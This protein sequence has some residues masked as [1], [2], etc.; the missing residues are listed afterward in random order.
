[1]LL[2]ACSDG[3][4]GRILANFTKCNPAEACPG[5]PIPAVSGRQPA[6]WSIPVPRRPQ[7]SSRRGRRRRRSRS[8]RMGRGRRA[9]RPPGISRALSALKGRDRPVTLSRSVSSGARQPYERVGYR[10]V[11]EPDAAQSASR[12]RRASLRSG[13]APVAD[14]TGPPGR[15]RL[16]DG[17]AAIAS[18]GLRRAP[19]W[20]RERGGRDRHPSAGAPSRK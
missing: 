20:I 18:G 14:E 19:I 1:M 13:S 11:D 12:S 5:D 17:R 2:P 4:P 6:L 10:E 9:S 8:C 3:K 7:P 16:R 15:G